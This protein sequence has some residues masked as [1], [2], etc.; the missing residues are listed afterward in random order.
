MAKAT[1]AAGSF[2]QAEEA[3]RH[4]PGIIGTTVGYMGG[5]VSNPTYE[6]V[7]GGH[8][9]HALVVEVEF[10]PVHIEYINLLEV[11]WTCHDPT[12]LNRQGKD[13][14]TQYRSAIFF[15]NMEQK[16]VALE[17][18]RKEQTLHRRQIVT[19]IVPVAEFYPA[20][21]MHQQY[22]EQHGLV[23]SPVAVE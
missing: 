4:L 3:F 9:G 19:E 10:D 23:G 16:E 22:L 17:S 20:E 5:T 8:T 6:D 11:F 18:R 2:W 15:H 13:E 14:G 7:A 12:S 1:F 21:K